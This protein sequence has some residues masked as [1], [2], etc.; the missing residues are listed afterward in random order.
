MDALTRREQLTAAIQED[1]GPI[2]TAHAAQLN[3]AA[4]FSPN[5]NTARKDLRALTAR[6]VLARID[7]DRHTYTRTDS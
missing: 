7:G 6:G 5:R 4:G 1:P 2:T 3:A